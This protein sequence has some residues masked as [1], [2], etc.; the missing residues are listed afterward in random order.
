MFRPSGS[1]LANETFSLD[2]IPLWRDCATIQILLPIG[3][4]VP[5]HF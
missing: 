1:P 2:K 4:L 3:R 5:P